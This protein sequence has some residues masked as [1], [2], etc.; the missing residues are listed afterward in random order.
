MH[1]ECNMFPITPCVLLS[2]NHSGKLKQTIIKYLQIQFDLRFLVSL[3]TGERTDL[4]AK[5]LIFFLCISVPLCGFKFLN[6]AE[7]LSM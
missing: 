5:T 3:N 4:Q 2:V 6:C 7:I 1:Y